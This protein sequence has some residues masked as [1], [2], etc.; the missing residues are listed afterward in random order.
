MDN[1][2]KMLNKIAGHILGVRLNDD[3]EYRLSSKCLI[4]VYCYTQGW[5]SFAEVC[6]LDND[7]EEI[8]AWKIFYQNEDE[9][10]SIVKV[11]LEEHEDLFDAESDDTYETGCEQIGFDT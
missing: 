6:L 7:R 3:F 1:L 8:E 5:K 9:A 11:I 2:E 10:R 4:H